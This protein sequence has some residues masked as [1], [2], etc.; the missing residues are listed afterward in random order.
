MRKNKIH[1][2]KMSVVASNTLHVGAVIVMLSA[3]VIIYLLSSSKCEQIMKQVGE[4]E[5]ELA[6]LE[7]DRVRE[8]IRWE[9]MKSTENLERQLAFFHL[10]KMKYPKEDQ[11]V[12]MRADGRPYPGQL[13]VARARQQNGLPMANYYQ[14]GSVGLPRPGANKR[15]SYRKL[16]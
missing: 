5:G 12:R 10:D 7:D 16:H 2:K 15:S 1:S 4:K 9:E 13:S 6:R 14:D 8:S 11:I 3:M